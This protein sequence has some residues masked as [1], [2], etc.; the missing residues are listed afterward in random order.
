MPRLGLAVALAA[1]GLW[2]RH[3]AQAFDIAPTPSCGDNEY[4]DISSLL[5]VT[6]G[7]NQEPDPTQMDYTN[8]SLACRCVAGYIATSAACASDEN[9]L[10][11][12]DCVELECSEYCPATDTAPLEDDSQCLACDN[13]TAVLNS[14]A[15]D[16]ACADNDAFD[17]VLL[18][19]DQGGNVAANKTCATCAAGTRVVLSAFSTAG[20]AYEADPYACV[21]C[22]D[23]NMSWGTSSLTID[24]CSCDTGYTAVGSS[25]FGATGCE[26]EDHTSE[27]TVNEAN[28]VTVSYK[29]VLKVVEGPATSTASVESLYFQD[30]YVKSAA[31][32][33]YFAEE[34]ED[35][36]ACQALANLCVLQQYA[37]DSQ[38]CEDFDDIR[39]ARVATN[40]GR[41]EW[42]AKMPWLVYD[43]DAE[44]VRDDRGILMDIAFTGDGITSFDTLEFKVAKYTANGTWLGTEDVSTLF[45]YCTLPAP[46]TDSGGGTSSSTRWQQVGHSYEDK[47]RCDL[48]TLLYDEQVFMDLYIVDKSTDT[49]FPVPVRNKNYV[50]A[51]GQ[52]PNLNEDI[53]DEI[54]DV[55][56]RRFFLY[57]VISGVA[58]DPIVDEDTGAYQPTVVRFAKNIKLKIRIQEDATTKIY[59][60]VLYIQYQDVIVSEILSETN[61]MLGKPVVH[62]AVEYSMNSNALY[63]TF[64]GFVSAG[65]VIAA[66]LFGLRLSNMYN[67]NR[68]HSYE[69]SGMSF[70]FLMRVLVLAMHSFNVTFFPLM[71]CLC[72]YLFTFF[73]M[74]AEVY[75]MLPSESAEE[76]REPISTVFI[77]FFHLMFFFQLARIIVLVYDQCHVEVFFVDWEKPKNANHEVSAWRQILIANEW[78]ALQT[79]RRTSV[80]ATLIWL[81]F[82]LIGAGIENVATP[83]PSLTDTRPGV[84]NPLLRF[85][86]A[87]FWWALLSVA[88]WLWNTLIYDRY[89]TE[90]P[91]QHFVDLC[92]IAKIS[93]VVFDSKFHG[94]YLH[95]NAPYDHADVTMKEL[96]EHLANE[97]KGFTTNRGLADASN[98]PQLQDVQVFEL[99]VTGLWRKKWERIYASSTVQRENFGMDRR[100][101]VRGLDIFKSETMKLTD[102]TVKASKD[103]TEYLKYFIQN[104]FNRVELKHELKDQTIPEKILHRP[105]EMGN[106]RNKLVPD[107]AL[108]GGPRFLNVVFLGNEADLL[109]FNMLSFAICDVWFQNT[110]ASILFTYVLNSAL[111]WVRR[112]FGQANLARKTL[113]DERFLI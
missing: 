3:Q 33:K 28:A 100:R 97:E 22:P 24:T 36:R 94:Y 12:G 79:K 2:A 26:L 29:N 44:D 105:P 57:D 50:R 56:T 46:Q 4:I 64:I 25:L 95:C 68:R 23:P 61:H 10:I 109:L 51:N 78:N 106:D 96:S 73:K 104:T 103:L 21:S 113:V 99:Y 71:F 54:D 45:H 5:C 76:G 39:D 41:A 13:S 67:N 62:F 16:C 70:E 15:T 55:Y 1:L 59:P 9:D 110:A 37:E 53:E 20:V 111:E 77:I 47:Y 63:E 87:M 89:F 58:S 35:Y 107:H 48:K 34:P 38:V 108:L 52:L 102:S 49:L 98:K 7:S 14:G 85:A 42:G 84:T 18:E 82:V 40:N 91:G 65:A 80:T 17:K 19:Y 72:A 6:C 11:D 75:L 74:Q 88:Q 32:C 31:R 93:V 66:F 112:T 69:M 8:N 30:L 83:Q 43:E 81:C 86:S 27:F 101:G 60:P 90:P 92:T